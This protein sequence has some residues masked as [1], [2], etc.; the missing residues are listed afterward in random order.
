MDHRVLG[1]R[2]GLG[3]SFYLSW[4]TFDYTSAG[5]NGNL[6][7]VRL[8]MDEDPTYLVLTDSIPLFEAVGR[9][10]GPA[11]DRSRYLKDPPVQA[12]FTTSGLGESQSGSIESPTNRIELVWHGLA[13]PLFAA[14]PSPS[15][16]ATHE[17]YSVLLEAET[18]SVR[19]DGTD[20]VGDPYLNDAWVTWLGRPL[21][22]ALV[23][24]GEI[25]VQAGVM[26]SVIP[27]RDINRESFAPYGKLLEVPTAFA[28]SMTREAWDACVASII[29]GPAEVRIPHLKRPTQAQTSGVEVH[30]RSPQL[31]LLPDSDW[32]L[33][34]FARGWSPSAN[35]PG[36][37]HAF[38]VA[39]HTL[40]LIDPGIWHAGVR[41]AADSDAFVAFK[42]G[43]LESGSSVADLESPIEV[44]WP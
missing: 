12:Q 4:Y 32:C 20:I 41:A 1:L 2:R 36:R 37:P 29:V 10:V 40:V 16:P 34:V 9:T 30:H 15:R 27:V 33:V 42:A 35:H 11:A 5:P 38:R 31:T 19:V 13:T 22:S 44:G 26:S 6:A 43:T 28:E 23:A 7:F 17:T 8:G 14:G 39:A 25:I 18:A 24:L 21:S 3:T